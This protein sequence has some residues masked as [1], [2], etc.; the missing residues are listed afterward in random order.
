MASQTKT[1]FT[2]KITVTPTDNS[3]ITV[4][5]SPTVTTSSANGRGI[6]TKVT[7]SGTGDGPGGVGSQPV[8]GPS[9]SIT[10]AYGGINAPK[11]QPGT[12][13]TISNVYG[14]YSR[15]DTGSLSGAITNAIAVNAAAPSL[16]S[17]VP[18]NVSG[19]VVNN[20]GAASETQAI[21]VDV[22]AQ[23]GAT[24]NIGVR[25]AKSNTYSLQLSDTGGTAAGGITFGTDLQVWRSGS[26]TLSV[27]DGATLSV[28]T[29]AGAKIAA[30]ASEKLGFFGVTPIAKPL[31]ATGAGHTVDD[32]ITVLQNL[33]L[34][35]QS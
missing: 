2:G 4:D 17:Q 8:F 10:S 16:G 23:S 31:L 6:Q 9:S 3:S 12:G 5:A 20:Q 7:F 30:S 24:T 1:D 34:V 29:T 14:T 15:V 18:T 25:I 27:T 11:A 21:G 28:G 32:V 22:N 35:R 26:A 13:V 19:V 33:G